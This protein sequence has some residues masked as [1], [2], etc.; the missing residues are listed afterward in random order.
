MRSPIPLLTPLAFLAI[1]AA[2]SDDATGPGDGLLFETSFEDGFDGFVPD[3]TDLDDPPVEW[4]IERTDE[5]AD[6]GEW[7][8]RLELENLNDAGK[9]WIERR[10]DLEPGRVYDVELSYAFASADF[11][12]INTW[13]IIAGVTPVDPETA[14]D[15]PFQGSTANG[16]DD[17]VGFV[18]LERNH[19]L[20]V[21][22]G[23]SG[24]AWVSLGVW[25]TFEV[26]RAYHLDDVRVT[27]APR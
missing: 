22:T 16:A 9:I 4:E 8:V 11:G 19:E 6:D 13:T 7:S 24:E 5:R 21:T 18:W 3:G 12:D 26:T 14:G 20:T 17:D 15:L 23:A 1:V 10:F 2:C 25:G 27:F